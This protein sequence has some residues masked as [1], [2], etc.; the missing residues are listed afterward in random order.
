MGTLT[1]S[2]DWA[3]HPMGPPETWP[4]SFRTALSIC[5]GSRFPMAIW[6]G[7]DLW[8]FYNDGYRH[9]LG[10]KHPKSLGQRGDECWAEIWDAVG[11][12][13]RQV[14]TTGEATFSTDFLLIMERNHY[15]EET[16][17]TFSYSPIRDEGGGV[18]GNLITVQET[19]ERVL[20]ERRL[21]TLSDLGTRAAEGKRPEEAC[22]IA[23][24]ILSGNPWD[25]PFALIYLL[26][27]DGRH[28]RL[29]GSTGVRLDGDAAP[30]VIAC[31]GPAVD[32]AGGWPL[33]A[34]LRDARSFRVDALA[35]RFLSAPAGP[36]PNP[37]VSA[38]VLPLAAP[39]QERPAG[40]LVAG[41]NPRR[42]LDEA[43][44]SF[45][46]L[47]A[48]QISTAIA[49]A[50]A[51]DRER[52]RAES[53]AELDRAKTAFFS[54][55][56]HEL[57][58]PLTLLL[59]P[60]EDVLAADPPLAGPQREN[61]E[62]A[63]RNALRLLRLVNTLLDFSRIEAG[64]IDA[65]YEPTDLAGLTV[66]LASAFRSAV[67]RAGLRL[68]VDCPSLDVEAWVDREMWEKIVFNLLSN[69]LKFTLEG[70][71]AVRV[72]LAGGAG[73]RVELSVADTGAG[74]P[75]DELPRVFERFRRVRTT[76]ARSHEG[77]GIGL[78]LVQELVRLHGG[79]VRVESTPGQGS[80]FT[81]SIPTGAAHLPAD[82]IGGSRR[83]ASTALGSTPFVEEALR[84]L[85]GP[86]EGPPSGDADPG[87]PR[88]LLA[89]DNADMRE[90][91]RRLLAERWTVEAAA[92]GRE[93]LARALAHP[94]DLILTDIMMPGLDGFELLRALRADPATRTV[95]VILLS[96]R[97]GQ[98]ARI[99]GL[100]AGADDY[101][102]KP[103]SARELVARV[104]SHLAA[105]R[106][107]REML[108]EE[109]AARRNAEA[110]SRAKDHFLA[111][112]S[113]ELRNP[114]GAISS[115]AQA[116]QEPGAA[117]VPRL[118]GIIT[119]QSRHLARL[120]DDLLDVSRVTAG[121]ITLRRS[122]VDLADVVERCRRTLEAGGRAGRHPIEV[123]AEAAW[124][125]GDA[126]RLEQVITNLLENAVKYT[127]DGKAI[128]LRLAPEG[129]EA[130]LS[131]RD[132]GIGIAP[133][134]LPRVFDLFVQ[135]DR[136]LD[137]SEG[138]MGLGLTLVRQLVEMHGGRV[139]AR[140]E[141]VGKGSEFQ[142]R[143]P[144]VRGPEA[145]DLPREAARRT[146]R[147]ILVIEDH[148]DA[149][150]AL[151]TLLE[152][153]G[154]EVEA[155]E[156]GRGG[157]ERVDAF[158]PDLILLDIGLPG[159]DGYEVARALARH[160]GRNRMRVVALTGYGQDSDRR[161]AEEAGFDGHL[162][163]PVEPARLREL[164]AGI[165]Q[166]PTAPAPSSSGTSGSAT[167]RPSS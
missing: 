97:A 141:G 107:G 90:Y 119:R 161:R 36:W 118:A 71:I 111:M 114:L 92:D 157:L 91:V 148:E 74:I 60:L 133:D 56:S 117:G 48:G 10:D 96:A 89:D 154:H 151:C 163:K 3:A 31:A 95:P 153:D 51:Y 16:Y 22:A 14:V 66:D 98:E 32:G 77:T 29:A 50:S 59:G 63:Q 137:R 52:Q 159:L 55:V 120:L 43:Y 134:M 99:E 86:A 19:T 140:S 21:R 39:G 75:E 108:A 81:V 85:P 37:P 15:L 105:A 65:V 82:R 149:R 88:V 94:P 101:L 58:T 127:P 68:V 20:G 122:P 47:A 72:R 152:L 12:F 5:L 76:Q 138:G 26:D 135:G 54:N 6:W 164:I 106:E 84:W 103:F 93:A 115:A 41:L 38:L 18:G 167:P 143:L 7:P 30:A 42:E 35:E 61:V 130:V 23:A 80:V 139:T 27:G 73:D 155:A 104:S 110:E 150:E 11:P 53:L 123:H 62:T 83:L 33:E 8:Q 87:R 160:P 158:Q 28:L 112:L 64:R 2:F 69:A 45:F 46:E 116:L 125:D 162:V 144:L 40:V 49:N 113:H 34:A 1:R 156:D 24:E 70:E 131:L 165:G 166:V 132:E 147:R 13:Y 78:A 9:I 25:V 109:Q 126:T 129:N 124:V 4:Q 57:R 100:D 142:V 79:E 136:D 121:K 17:F 145:V 67:E 128:R 44:R 146:A 102:V